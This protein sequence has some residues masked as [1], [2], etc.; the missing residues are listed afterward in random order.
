MPMCQWQCF[1]RV[2][3]TSTY[4]IH[5]HTF[6]I[7]CRKACLMLFLL[8]MSQ[9]PVLEEVEAGVTEKYRHIAPRFNFQRACSSVLASD[10][11]VRLACF[12]MCCRTS[13]AALYARQLQR[14]PNARVDRGSSQEHS[15][16]ADLVETPM[17]SSGAKPSNRWSTASSGACAWSAWKTGDG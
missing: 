1:R 10:L 12:V 2:V 13:G 11:R 4:R 3:F 7:E 14:L 6:P 15:T 17:P 5:H 16:G 8:L 9:P